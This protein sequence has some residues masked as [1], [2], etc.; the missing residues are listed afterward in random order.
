MYK[1]YADGVLIYDSTLEDY[2][3]GKGQIT[4]EVGKSGSFVFSVYPDH[5]YYDRFVQ[6]KTVI[7]VYKSGR[8]V[9]RGRVLDDVTDYW[10]NK[11]LTCEGELGFLNDSIIRPYLFEGRPAELFARFIQMHNEQVDAFKHFKVGTVDIAD[12]NDYIARDNTG[13][14]ST[15]SNLTSRL[16][17]SGLG[18]YI[19]VTHGADGTEETPTIHYVKDF[20]RV[21]T[22]GIEFGVNLKDFTKTTKGTEIA[23]AIIPFGAQIDDGDANTENRRLTIES[24]NG[25]KDYVYDAEA[26]A[27][28]GWI[29][30][31]VT[32]DDVT[33][34][35]NLKAKAE[36]WLATGVN[37]ATTI[38]L[39]AI[40]LHLLDRSIE[41]YNVCEYVPVSSAPHGFAEIMLCNRQ[42][43][44]LLKPENDTVVLGYSYRSFTSNST[45]LA[46]SVS[47]LSLMQSDVSNEV[48]KVAQHV[49]SITL[50]V[51]NTETGSYIALKAG[52]T[53]ISSLDINLK[54]LVTFESLGDA[55]GEGVT[56]IN[57]GWIDADT[58]NVNAANI[59]G[60]LVASKI[61]DATKTSWIQ[62]GSRLDRYGSFEQYHSAYEDG[63]SPAT[64]IGIVQLSGGV[65]W[66]TLYSMGTSI[67][68]HSGNTGYT[69]PKGTWDFSYCTTVGLN[70]TAVFA[71]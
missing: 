71:S 7:T 44:D 57:G 31:T 1:I 34:A 18:G 25:G 69:L 4:L 38:E 30:Q 60:V 13:Y 20:S 63:E 17:D 40:D 66:W 10:N 43:M 6:M 11:T 49:N 22:Q 48:S 16:P 15:Q 19:Y 36:S 55:P 37:L 28:R 27:Y 59:S 33:I 12:P 58:L 54:G 29:F 62:I 45:K 42:T 65:P 68:E 23:T 50:S 3:I 64:E 26:V 35:S 41:S 51:D 32:W 39:T 24:V 70:V 14:E 47:N 2:R 46:F 53:T 9:F 67:L 61:A 8:I 56:K 21:A 52:D 5:F